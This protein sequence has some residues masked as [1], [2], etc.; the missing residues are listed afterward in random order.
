MFCPIGTPVVAAGNGRIADTGDSI[1]PATG[2]F[3]TIDLDDGRRVRY[4]HLLGRIVKVGDRVS[5][6]QV[7]GHS[8][9]SGYGEADWSWN[10][11][12]TGGAHV[13]MTLWPLH[14]YAFGSNGSLDPEQYF[15]SNAFAG[16]GATPFPKPP[17]EEEMIMGVAD[18]ITSKVAQTIE[19]KKIRSDAIVWV[20]GAAFVVDDA[21]G[22]KWNVA[23]GQQTI[24]DAFAYIRWL[25]ARG[26]TEYLNQPPFTLAGY[27]DITDE[28]SV[29]EE[30]A[31]AL[32]DLE[33]K[34]IAEA[35]E[36]K[37]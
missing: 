37:S 31:E 5:R 9:A 2:R 7:I 18:D 29:R 19:D 15:D 14:L 27:R 23:R 32:R 17:T 3:V 24:E 4:L 36:A 8:G 6:G 1:Q 11:A 30:V 28:G 22:T 12:E 33:Q 13:H 35:R 21:A 10:V 26:F 20:D 34:K 25:T 16:S